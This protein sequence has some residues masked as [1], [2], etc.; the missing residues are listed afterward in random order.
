MSILSNT[1]QAYTPANA[2][3]HER[4]CPPVSPRRSGQRAFSTRDSRVEPKTS[5]SLVPE[6][7]HP[8][9]S[10]SKSLC[11]R[12][13]MGSHRRAKL[14]RLTSDD[15]ERMML[16]RALPVHF[17][18]TQT[19]HS[20]YPALQSFTYSHSPPVRPA[21]MDVQEGING[22]ANSAILPHTSMNTQCSSINFGHG[23]G[24]Q[25]FTSSLSVTNTL[26]PISPMGDG[27]TSSPPIEGAYYRHHNT[28][29]ASLSSPTNFSAQLRQ[30]R[31]QIEERIHNTQPQSTACPPRNTFPPYVGT[32]EQN[33][34][35]IPSQRL[36]EAIIP[37]IESTGRHDSAASHQLRFSCKSSPPKT[38]ASTDS[39]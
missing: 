3:S 39:L 34:K 32:V 1:I 19:L 16:S 18:T 24:D 35:N 2:V 9:L 29:V 13:L 28:R 31:L 12:K 26:A 5:T 20:P 25:N 23:A 6:Q 4:I 30:P 38:R 21:Q 7:V 15:R 37:G 17:D 36:N 10:K 22:L 11:C 27:A 33:D 14:K 8:D